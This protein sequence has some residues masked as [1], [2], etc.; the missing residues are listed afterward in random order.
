MLPAIQGDSLWIEYGTKQRTR[1]IL[2]D[3]GPINAFP[4]VEKKIKT[5][6]DGDKRIELI[7]VTHVDTDHIEGIIRL[8]AEER[9]NWIFLPA[10]IWFNGWR[11]LKKSNTLGGREGDFC[12][13][14]IRKRA[15]NEWNKAF[16]GNAVVVEENKPLPVINLEGGMKI[17]LLSPDMNKLNEMVA[18]W[19]ADVDKFGLD[20]GDLD[21]AWK[22]LISSTKY[23]I[24]KGVLGGDSDFEKKL[25]KQLS[26]DQSVAN[27]TSIAFL[28]EFEGKSC[29]F[30]GDA[31][32]DIICR[33]IRNLL[34]AKGGKLK[35][36]AVKISH[37]GSRNNISK[38]LLDLIDS[39][40]YLFSTNGFKHKHPNK[41]SVEAVINWSE[42]EPTLWFNYKTEYTL[43]WQKSPAE[44][45]KLFNSRYPSEN[46]EGIRIEL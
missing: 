31:H 14:L 25:E 46:K 13:A 12:S 11:H 6:P 28:A 5:L 23:H 16:K 27:G 41:S 15:F 20:P 21:K 10:D 1:R 4:S 29:L 22:Q 33:S 42:Q 32:H 24:S 39:K 3:G 34:G 40:N 43:P 37:H 8:F 30:L 19:E 17:T 44:G 45:K 38:E 26:T 35:V 2:I 7:V 18:K 9:S 36:D